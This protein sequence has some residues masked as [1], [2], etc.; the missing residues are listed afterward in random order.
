MLTLQSSILNWIWMSGKAILDAL[1]KYS[2]LRSSSSSIVIDIF[3]YSSNRMRV[4]TLL[5]ASWLLLLSTRIHAHMTQMSRFATCLAYG[6]PVDLAPLI[7]C[8]VC[9]VQRC[10]GFAGCLGMGWVLLLLLPGAWCTDP[11]SKGG[12]CEPG[13]LAHAPDWVHFA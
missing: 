11:S 1:T 13:S 6:V 4:A 9:R 10:N 3:L 5:H 2:G 8:K 7:G 12:C